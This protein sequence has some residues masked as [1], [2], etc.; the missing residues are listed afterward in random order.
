MSIG[1]NISFNTK[2]N[3]EM[4]GYIER[5]NEILEDMLKMHVMDQQNQWEKYLSLVEFV[6]KNSY[7]SSIHVAAYEFL[8]GGPYKTPLIG[9]EP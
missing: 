9:I 1:T 3:I 4:D 5:V 6:Y 7:H 8:Y 2:C